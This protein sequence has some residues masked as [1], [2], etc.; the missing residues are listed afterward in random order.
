MK[1]FESLKDKCLQ[2]Q[3]ELKGFILNVRSNSLLTFKDLYAWVFAVT[4]VPARVPTEVRR[5]PQ[6]AL[7][8]EVVLSRHVDVGN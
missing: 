8:L 4:Y 7:E 3:A 6:I 1:R 2:G 5:E